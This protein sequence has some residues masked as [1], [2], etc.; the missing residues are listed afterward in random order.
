MNQARVAIVTDSTSDLL[1][2]LVAERGISVVPLTVTLDGQSYLDGVDITPDEFYTKL[3]SSGG[4]ATTSQPSPGRFAETYERLLA[5]HDEVVSLHISSE[6]SGT[7]AAARQGG[8]MAGAGRVH[9]LDTGMV[10]M[11][12]GL[13]ALVAGAMA[14]EG[15][16]PAG[17]G[18]GGGGRLPARA[19]PAGDQAAGLARR[20]VTRARVAR[21]PSRPSRLRDC[22]WARPSWS[23]M[24]M[25]CRF[26]RKPHT[27][28]VTSQPVS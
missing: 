24:R 9:V 20:H 21:F 2:S 22:R 6:L 26:F 17:P 7:Y 23:A 25:S 4:T 11:P 8:D 1:P 27:V 13:M 15:R 16:P 10:S 12:L 19:V 5:D 3:A 18:A 14:A 28:V